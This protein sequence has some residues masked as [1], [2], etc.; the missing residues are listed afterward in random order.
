MEQRSA[1]IKFN[2][3]LQVPGS[4]VASQTNAIP[5]KNI[6]SYIISGAALEK[7]I[8]LEREAQKIT[9]DGNMLS[10]NDSSM[11]TIEEDN[12]LINIDDVEKN[13]ELT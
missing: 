5:N 6:G 7:S 3:S 1:A 2:P 10:L 11:T 13:E 9:K 8:A 12:K 4:K